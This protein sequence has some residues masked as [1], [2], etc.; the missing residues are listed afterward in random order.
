MSSPGY[1]QFKYSFELS[2]I[3]LT[4]GIAGQVPGGM[5]PIISLTQ[6]SDF[7]M[8]IL[9]G[10]E[11]IDPDD[12][13][14]NF[15]PIIG[16][17]LIDNQIGKYPFANQSVAAN[18]II[19]QPLTISLTMYCPVRN[20]GGYA[21]KLATMTALQSALKQH[22]FSG[23]TY[24]IATPSYYYTNC[25]MTGMRDASNGESKQAQ[26]AFTLDFEQPL[27]TLEQAKQEENS[28]MSKISGGTAIQGQP[29]WS[30]LPPTVGQPGS[31]AGSSTIP[32]QGGAAGAGVS[33]G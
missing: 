22:N 6:G 28:L 26:N 21:A 33:G 14:A 23:G 8:G 1:S 16:G 27:L 15:V 7:D 10:S 32:A 24:T 30:G 11:D 13:F 20:A 31:L 2:P 17:S 12:F 18:A 19:A 5:L 25:V 29:A 4:G 9:S 3:I